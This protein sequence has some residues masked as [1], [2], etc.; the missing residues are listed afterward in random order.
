M[1]TQREAKT[2]MFAIT[3]R[4]ILALSGGFNL[5]SHTGD[6]CFLLFSAKQGADI[7]LPNL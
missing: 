6:P 2:Y 3:A 1:N 7:S 4:K 5:A